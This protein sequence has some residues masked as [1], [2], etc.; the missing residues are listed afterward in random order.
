MA[1]K[2]NMFYVQQSGAK[3]LF[4]SL[5]YG[6]FIRPLAFLNKNPIMLK[7]DSF[8]IVYFGLFA[9]CG[10]IAGLS[11]SFFYLYA[12]GCF[13]LAPIPTALVLVGAHLIG[14]KALYFLALGKKFFLNPKTYLNETTMYNQG[15]LFGVVIATAAIAFIKHIDP[16]IM[17][18]AMVLGSSF[19]LFLG[20]L[21]CYNYG[22][23]FGIP[24]NS[25]IHV[26]YLPSCSKIIRTNPELKG[27]PL[28]PTQLYSAYFDLFLFVISVAIALIHRGNGL[29]FLA[30]IF[31]F[32]GFRVTIQRV[33]FVEKSDLAEFSK[34]AVLYFAAGLIIWVALF[35][36]GG[37]RMVSTPFLVPFTFRS[38]IQF[39]VGPKVML[40]LLITGAISF[41]FYGVHGKELGNHTN[42]RS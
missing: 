12:K 28:V 18:D 7:T 30:F 42:I 39:V 36:A 27:V 22:C 11:I 2:A 35:L 40:S 41:L 8:Q 21:G 17:F 32:N 19:G 26:T 20:R 14:V 24:T 4:H 16:L 6:V 33:R 34:I 5:I 3:H 13:S 25:S 31:L 1:D 9:A 37:G 23:C 38:W 15:G 29:I 10:V